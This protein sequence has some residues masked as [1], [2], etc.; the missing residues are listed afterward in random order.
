L[1]FF[2]FDFD[3]E[4]SLEPCPLSLG[5]PLTIIASDVEVSELDFFLVS[6]DSSAPTITSNSI[7][8]VE[9]KLIEVTK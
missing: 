3:R 7:L 4:K 5:L 6:S 9:L 2:P 1:L 8:Y